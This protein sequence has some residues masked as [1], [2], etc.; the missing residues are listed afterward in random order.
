MPIQVLSLN[1]VPH[2]VREEGICCCSC[3]KKQYGHM[4]ILFS[5]FLKNPQPIR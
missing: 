5:N 3:L 1:P 4:I 2:I